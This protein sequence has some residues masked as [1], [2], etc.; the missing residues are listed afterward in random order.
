M[1]ILDLIEALRDVYAKEGN[2]ETTCTVSLEKDG[3]RDGVED[4]LPTTYESTVENLKVCEPTQAVKFKR[5]RM[6]W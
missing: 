1:R 6:Y 2:I 4:V 5:V 3:T